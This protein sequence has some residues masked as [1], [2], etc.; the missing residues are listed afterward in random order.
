M[1][2]QQHLSKHKL[3]IMNALFK[4]NIGYFN[5]REFANA[6]E[7]SFKF[8]CEKYDIL[9]CFFIYKCTHGHTFIFIVIVIFSYV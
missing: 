3:M 6:Q 1:C 9:N 4:C 8:F 7:L 5:P 2:K